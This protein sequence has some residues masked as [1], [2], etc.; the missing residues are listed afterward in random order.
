MFPSPRLFFRRAAFSLS[1][2]LVALVII[3][4]LLL[5]GLRV[6]GRN[7]DEAHKAQC[8]G[9][10]RQL[11]AAVYLYIAD[12]QGRLP[13]VQVP[14]PADTKWAYNIAPYLNLDPVSAG[15]N[16]PHTEAFLCPAD[17]SRSPKQL[18]TYRYHHTYPSP[19]GASLVYKR[20]NYVPTFFRE[21]ARPATH[22]MIFCI[23]YTGPIRYALWT[24]NE[25]LWT[26]RADQNTQPNGNLNFNRPHY[27]GKAI[28]LL[29]SDGH[30]GKAQYPLD[31]LVWHFD[32]R[33]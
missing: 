29:Y 11:G 2:L 20:E 5:L 33:P 1:E 22:G 16:I 7:R 9:K 28:Q 15:G 30:A 13:L 10:L 12:H 24:P 19:T 25:A 17:P 14:A 18:R 3:G 27:N 6:A 8:L 23:A 21:I 31:P 26:K 32:G 4:V